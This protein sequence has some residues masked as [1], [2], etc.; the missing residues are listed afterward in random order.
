MNPKIILFSILFLTIT[1]SLFC[2]EFSTLRGSELLVGS[3]SEQ[4]GRSGAGIALSNS[5]EALYWNPAGIVD[6]DGL[7]FFGSANPLQGANDFS[8]VVPGNRISFIPNSISLAAGYLTRLRF[9]GDSKDEIWSGFSHHLLEMAMLDLGDDFQGKIDS[10]TADFRLAVA[11]EKSDS[12]LKLGT[13][14]CYLQ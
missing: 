5:A 12:T 2:V 7:T 14:I 1:A 13:T 4:V 11:W 8:I 6:S 3:G 9:K 10:R